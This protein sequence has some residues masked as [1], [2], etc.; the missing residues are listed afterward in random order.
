LG[1]IQYKAIKTNTK[2]KKDRDIYDIVQFLK[3]HIFRRSVPL[4]KN[5]LVEE[6]THASNCP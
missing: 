1:K 6:L 2:I 3:F 5:S 4:K